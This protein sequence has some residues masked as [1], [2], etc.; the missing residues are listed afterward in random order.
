MRDRTEERK[1]FI[2]CRYLRVLC[3]FMVFR[4]RRGATLIVAL[5]I[6]L[7]LALIGSTIMMLSVNDDRMINDRM[8]N[9]GAL[10]AAEAGI[11]ESIKRLSLSTEDSLFLGDPQFAPAPGWTAYLLLSKEPPPHQPP[12]YYKKSVQIQLPESLRIPYST[13][14]VDPKLTLK[15]SHKRDQGG[16]GEIF[17]YNWDEDTQ[18]SHTPGTYKGKYF[19]VELIQVTGRSGT[20]ARTLQVE[21]AKGALVPN[22]VAA[23]SS[24]VNIDITGKFMCCGHNH[25]CATPWGT[26]AGNDR[27]ECFGEPDMEDANWHVLRPDGKSHGGSAPFE[28]PEGDLQCSE[29][30][31]IPGISAPGHGIHVG[32]RALVRGN[33]DLASDSRGVEFRY[34]YEILNT[35]SWDELKERFLWQ[36]IEPG[37][38]DGGSFVGYYR[39]EGDLELRGV[40]NFTGVL[41]VTGTLRQ[42][43]YFSAS[44]IVYAGRSCACNGNVWILGA[45]AIEGEGQS[46]VRPFNGS[47]VLLY[48]V[49]GIERALAAAGGYRI[50]ARREK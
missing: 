28:K 43:G 12:V 46:E 27:L 17:Y 23:L 35:A 49:D 30:G 40:V 14:H 24:N 26:N 45:V 16:A 50:I 8:S 9:I 31:C 20:V 10:A 5:I 21:V 39:C 33:P 6:L 18:E 48:S 36:L 44:G 4:A 3:G 38:I 1:V 41:W 29:A 15:I 13:E 7:L 37:T 2:T 42:R 47:G 32:D 25:L 11:A 19:P 34:L 22:V